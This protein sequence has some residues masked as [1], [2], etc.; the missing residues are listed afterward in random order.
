M[1]TEIKSNRNERKPV[2]VL[3][4]VPRA[5]PRPLRGGHVCAQ[6]RG[7]GVGAECGGDG[8][9]G[10]GVSVAFFPVHLIYLG[11]RRAEV[12]RVGRECIPSATQSGVVEWGVGLYSILPSVCLSR[13]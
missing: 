5:A 7:R 3:L 12:E 10:E 1:L 4:P 13:S 6:S 11:G 2:R 9:G 8:G